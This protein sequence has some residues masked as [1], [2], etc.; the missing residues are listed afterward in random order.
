MTGFYICS[1]PEGQ[2]VGIYKKI[3]SQNEKLTQE[4]GHC[5]LVNLPYFNPSFSFLKKVL[6]YIWYYFVKQF[7]QL[8]C[9]EKQEFDYLYIRR[10]GT[11][12]SNVIKFL[13]SCKKHNPNAKI[14][15]EIPT[16]PYYKEMIGISGKVLSWIDKKYSKCLSKYV[17]R[18]VTFSADGEIFGIKTIPITNG[19][20]CS[21]IVV[22]KLSLSKQSIN[23]IAVAQFAKWHG[24]DRLICGLEKYY[25]S[26]NS[27]KVILHIVG[28]GSELKK[29]KQAVNTSAVLQ[30]SVIFYGEKSGKE[31]DD[32]FD[33]VDIGVCS[34]GC[35]RKNIY[36]SSELKSR[37]YMA[38]G[39]PF[40]ASTPID[41]VPIDYKYCLYVPADE[42]DI[43]INDIINFYN[44]C[45]KSSNTSNLIYEMRSYAESTCDFSITMQPVFQYINGKIQ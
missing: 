9:I 33:N 2:A 42:S 40:I 6:F 34:L 8:K 22:R 20:D 5:T 28:D 24:I 35:H 38:R 37:E 41:S 1:V 27:E 16:Y 32:I 14:I 39:I 29:Y 26:S 17:D 31:L 36:K 19:I 25:Q 23:L 12:S 18:V 21:S 7:S 44:K 30:N 4:V 11:F 10:F 3:I 43:N 45:Y 13:R 15:L